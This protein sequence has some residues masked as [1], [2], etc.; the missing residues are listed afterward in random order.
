MQAGKAMKKR[1]RFFL[2]RVTDSTQKVAA[3]AHAEVAT[4]KPDAADG[5]DRIPEARLQSLIKKVTSV[6]VGE[7]PPG[8]PPDR[9]VGHV[10]TLEQGARPTYRPSRRLSP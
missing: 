1:D 5:T 6:L 4:A 2:V 3:C 8:L 9:G 10:I 7:L